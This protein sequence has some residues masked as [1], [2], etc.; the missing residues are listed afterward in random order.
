M[1]AQLIKRKQS[2]EK[3]ALNHL[4][5]LF[6]LRPILQGQLEPIVSQVLEQ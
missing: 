6:G 2:L 4:L 5:D 1:E 3:E